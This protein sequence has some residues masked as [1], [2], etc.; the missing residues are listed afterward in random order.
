MLSVLSCRIIVLS[1]LVLSCHYVV[2]FFYR[3]LYVVFH[4]FSSCL[5]FSLVVIY[6]LTSLVLPGLVLWLSCDYRVIGL[7]VSVPCPCLC[8]CPCPC[9][10]H[11]PCPCPC[12][13]PSPPLPSPTHHTH[14]SLCTFGGFLYRFLAVR[15]LFLSPCHCPCPCPCPYPCPFPV[16]V[17][18]LVPSLS[19]PLSC[20]VLSGLARFPL[21][22]SC[23][24]LFY[25]CLVWSF[26]V[27]VSAFC[28]VF[29]CPAYVD[30]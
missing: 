23:F 9:P 10:F 29:S 11:C 5:F 20:L 3:Y 28:L 13:C 6:V 18:V 22:L 26:L 15:S 16:I 7:S 27:S 25:F 21:V 17:L 1:Y 12:P 30:L 4:T 19:L 2:S 8:P 14:A 24:G